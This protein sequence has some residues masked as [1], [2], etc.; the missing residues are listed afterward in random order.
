MKQTEFSTRG[1]TWEISV[2]SFIEPVREFSVIF[3]W[4]R[5]NSKWKPEDKKSSVNCKRSLV[6]LPQK[7]TAYFLTL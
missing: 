7:L 3:L 1:A 5:S 6:E 2:N 4:A